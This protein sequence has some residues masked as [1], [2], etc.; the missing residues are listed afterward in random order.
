MSSRSSSMVRHSIKMM[1][2]TFVS[3]ILGL[4][5][6]VLIASLFGATGKLDAFLVAYT[7]ANLTRRLL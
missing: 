3:R 7:L 1:A 2:G 6:E 4:L 5:R